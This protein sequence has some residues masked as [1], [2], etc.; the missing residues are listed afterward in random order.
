[1]QVNMFGGGLVSTW[2][3]TSSGPAVLELFELK[4]IIAQNMK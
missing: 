3:L 1:M 2:D 4:E